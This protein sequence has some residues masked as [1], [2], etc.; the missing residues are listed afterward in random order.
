MRAK[1]VKNSESDYKPFMSSMKQTQNI[2]NLDKLYNSGAQNFPANNNVR[3]YPIPDKHL[4]NTSL[5]RIHTTRRAQVLNQNVAEN[6]EQIL[7]ADS[8]MPA[9]ERVFIRTSPRPIET[10]TT[11]PYHLI[12]SE[13]TF[14]TFLDKDQQKAKVFRNYK[15]MSRDLTKAYLRQLET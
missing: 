13:N 3:L 6:P 15:K 10:T 2:S 1:G 8:L 9:Q 12:N 7:S 11:F 5:D 14:D 4:A